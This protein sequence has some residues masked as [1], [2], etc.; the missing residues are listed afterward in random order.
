[1]LLSAPPLLVSPPL[2]VLEPLVS[3]GPPLVLPGSVALAL[4]SAALV[5]VPV[6]VTVTIV[7]PPPSSRPTPFAH[8]GATRRIDIAKVIGLPRPFAPRS[9]AHP[10]PTRSARSS[11]KVTHRRE[12]SR[13]ADNR[14]RRLQPRFARARARSF[15]R[16]R[17]AT[18]VAY[19]PA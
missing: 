2:L 11:V 1:V 16:P 10:T 14:S 5:P 6:A 15:A 4:V 13:P 18:C 9:M 7:P 12:Q 3:S 17:G 19:S 8:A